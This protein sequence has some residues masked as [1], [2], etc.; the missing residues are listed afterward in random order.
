M[1][2]TAAPMLALALAIGAALPAAV[3]AFE[4][5][6]V[7]DI[8]VDGLQRISAGTVFSYL[9]VE[10]GDTIDRNRA[11]DAIRALF[12]TGFFSDVKIDRQGQILVVTVQERPA[13]NKIT[14]TG[15]KDLKTEDLTRA[16]A[17]IGLSEG[18]TFNQLSLDRVTQE[19]VRQYNNRGKYN[20][21][22]RPSVLQL[23]RNRVDLTI[24]VKEGK[25]AR[26]RHINIIGNTAFPEEDIRDEWESGTTNWRSWYTRN[27]QYSREKVSGDLEKL[28]SYYLDR[29]YVDFNI[30]ST[31][32]ATS[33]DRR[34]MYLTTSVRE[35][36]VYSISDVEITGD[37][38]LPV[39]E[40][41]KLVLVQPG[42]TFSRRLLEMTSDAMTAVLANVGYAF[43]QVTPMPTVDRDNRTVAINFFVEPGQRVYVRRIV[44]KGNQNTADEVLRREMRQFEGMWYSQAAID[45]SK[46]RLDRLGFFEAVEIETPQV[47]GS[48][49]QVDV[50]FS[51][52]ERNSG[53]F[54]FGVGYS[55][56]SGIITSASV[57]QNNFFGTGNRIGVTVQN[58]SYAKRMDFSYFDPYFTD[59]GVSVGYNLYYRELNQQ[60]YNIANYTSNN[61]AAQAVFGVPLTET[62]SIALTF[63]IDSNE[64]FPSEGYTP[65][66]IVDYINTVGRRTFHAW[67]AEL[68]WARDS[69]NSLYSPTAGS[70]HRFAADI[71]LPGSTAEY[72]KL[73]YQ[74]ARYWP[75]SRSLVL[76]TAAELGYGDAY[77]SNSALGLPFFENFYAG[78]VRSIRGFEDNTLGPTATAPL[79]PDFR[80]PLGG[81]LKTTGTVEAIFPSIFDKID[82]MRISAFVDFGNVFAGTEAFDVGEF[83]ASTGFS[84]QWQAP[85]GPIILNIAHPLMKKDGDRVERIQ[86][87]FGTQ[88]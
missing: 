16:L 17:D 39:D 59:N 30:E 45:R 27:D 52:K 36:E 8:R 85:V 67:R 74:F 80:Q 13:I 12:R 18:E 37:T 33:P 51:V 88:F 76:L 3:H 54:M 50:E 78:G 7:S 23:D 11:G 47:P 24:L 77:G 9:P 79:S 2:R 61:G 62:D 53:S 19:L 43:A 21:S 44:F 4:P 29:G 49:D 15:N 6:V 84:L 86:F 55:Q 70:F 65:Q 64:I 25:A 87:S 38:I 20:V 42:Q 41:Q 71:T 32:V 56:L 28:T 22:V 75:V 60:R 63:G 82:T 1:T 58:N 48:P 31:Q 34:D 40:L 35:G 68:A 57:V 69:R 81:S 72:Y 10:R 83:R 5:F 26:L 73:N 66:P 14:L 46:V